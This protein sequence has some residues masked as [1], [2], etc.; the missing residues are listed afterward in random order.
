MLFKAYVTQATVQ[1]Y[2]FQYFQNTIRK[3]N[4]VS[5]FI[6]IYLIVQVILYLKR[7]YVLPISMSIHKKLRRK[8]SVKNENIIRISQNECQ[9]NT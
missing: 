1:D 7:V 8:A 3:E 5:E 2:G 4:E 6:I 9:K